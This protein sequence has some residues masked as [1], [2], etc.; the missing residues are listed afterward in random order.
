MQIDFKSH[1]KTAVGATPPWVR[2]PPLPPLTYG[3]IYGYSDGARRTKRFAAGAKNEQ[4]APD[5][6]YSIYKIVPK[7]RAGFGFRSPIWEGGR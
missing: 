7:N 5:N 4:N 1:L 6:V 2:I 3:N